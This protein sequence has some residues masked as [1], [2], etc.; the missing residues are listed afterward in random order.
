MLLRSETHV[1]GNTQPS[2]VLTRLS[3][4]GCRSNPSRLSADYGL[5]CP[6]ELPR[7]VALE[8]FRDVDHPSPDADR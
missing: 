3:R 8:V 4:P 5:P 1:K 6:G 2:G 7:L